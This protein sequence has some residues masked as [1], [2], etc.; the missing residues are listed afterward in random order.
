[1][2]ASVVV[3]E[4][5]SQEEAQG[6]DEEFQRLFDEAMERQDRIIRTL[7][8]NEFT[9]PSVENSQV[10]SYLCITLTGLQRAYCYCW[11]SIKH[12]F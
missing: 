7:S 8:D 5:S 9:L 10:I 3:M 1:M 2:H 4:S 6:E 11:K 12:S